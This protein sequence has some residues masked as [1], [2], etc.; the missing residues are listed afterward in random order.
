[1]EEKEKNKAPM[2]DLPFELPPKTKPPEPP[3][4]RAEVKQGLDGTIPALTNA[5]LAYAWRLLKQTLVG[6]V[7]EKANPEEPTQHV[8][9]I[10]QPVLDDIA[11]AEKYVTRNYTVTHPPRSII[12]LERGEFGAPEILDMVFERLDPFLQSEKIQ[13]S[14]ARI[15]GAIADKI[16]EGGKT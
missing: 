3:K 10:L 8:D 7:A 4:V 6:R 9:P 13:D 12:P 5:E 11:K 14:V 16:E 1:M 2:P 15:L